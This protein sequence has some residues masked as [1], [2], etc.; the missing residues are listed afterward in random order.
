MPLARYKEATEFLQTVGDP[1]ARAFCQ[2]GLATAVTSLPVHPSD[3][4]TMDLEQLCRLLVKMYERKATLN[5]ILEGRMSELTW[6]D[7]A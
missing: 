1:E 2:Y 5:L 4:A 6:F 7:D 3:D